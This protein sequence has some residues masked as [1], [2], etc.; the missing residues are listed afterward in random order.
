M[1]ARPIRACL[2]VFAVILVATASVAQDQ[3]VA[4][5]GITLIDGLADD[6]VPNATVVIHRGLIIHAGPESDVSIPEE[7]RVIDGTGKFMMPGLWDSHAHLTYWGK[8]A[9]GMLVRTGVTSIRELGGDIDSVG[10][11][12]S[13]VEAGTRLGPA[14]IWCGPYLEGP[15]APDEYRLKVSTPAEARSAVRDLAARGV[16]FIKIQAVI[17]PTL[18]S[19]LIEEASSRGMMVVG[20]VPRGLDAVQA[21]ELGLRS[22]EHMGPYLDLTDEKLE[23][24]FEIFKENDTWMSPT[25]HSMVAPIIARGEDPDEDLTVQR[26]RTIVRR[27]WEDGVGILVG[28]NFAYRTWPQQ[29]GS[30]LHGEMHALVEAGIPPMYVIRLATSKAA[31]FNGRSGVSGAIRPGLSADLVLLRA[32]PLED[33]RNSERIETVVLRGQ[34][35]ESVAD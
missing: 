25:L 31:A 9:L 32:D 1:P 23:R 33:I 18:V 14:M 17:G 20:H 13:E 29:P 30:G 12:K 5:A 26:A 21:S 3:P 8:E 15:D 7:A 4:F 24:T 28:A 27:A 16:D 35:I 19:A 2:T 11:W 10:A 22:V 6:P 34:L